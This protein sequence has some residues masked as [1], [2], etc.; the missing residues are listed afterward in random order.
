MLPVLEAVIEL[1][2]VRV[3][4][5]FVEPYLVGQSETGAVGPQL[6]FEDDL[7]GCSRLRLYIFRNEAVCEASLAEESTLQILFGDVRA[8]DSA[9]VFHDDRGA[10]TRV[11]L[12]VF[13]LRD[14]RRPIVVGFS[15]AETHGSEV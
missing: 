8:V 7:R 13:I 9:Y 5:R 4:Q 6:L 11:A 12:F 15:F 10:L 2:D 1:D 14:R 3:M